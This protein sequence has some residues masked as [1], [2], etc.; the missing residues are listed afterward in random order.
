[1][2]LYCTYGLGDH[3]LLRNFLIW[4]AAAAAAEGEDSADS[5]MTGR[6][7]TS[8]PPLLLE[9]DSQKERMARGALASG[10]STGALSKSWAVLLRLEEEP[11][12]EMPGRDDTCQLHVQL[13][14]C[15]S[16]YSSSGSED[17]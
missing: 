5:T 3:S 8:S 12:C 13:Q 10:V 11:R 4:L 14:Q 7:R 17:P 2:A 6:W 9:P 15:L 16:S 1:M